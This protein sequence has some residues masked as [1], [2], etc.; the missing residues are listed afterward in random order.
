M[1]KQLITLLVAST[2]TAASQNRSTNANRFIES[3][4]KADS[5]I[6]QTQEYK[7]M[8]YKIFETLNHIAIEL[9]P[10]RQATPLADYLIAHKIRV[11]EVRLY[12]KMN[13][14]KIIIW[15]N[16]RDIQNIIPELTQ[17]TIIYINENNIEREEYDIRL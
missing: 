5:I 14:A 9:S 16:K 4:H 2:L 13:Q 11:S 15:T 3:A 12:F 1:K 8:Q 17:L 10:M 6:S 7:D